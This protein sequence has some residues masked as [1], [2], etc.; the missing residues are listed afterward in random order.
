MKIRKVA[1]LKENDVL[2]RAVMTDDYQILLSEGVILKKE[3]IKKLKEF[4]IQDVY[5]EENKHYNILEIKALSEISE[6]KIK[7]N[8]KDILERHVYHNSKELMKLTE[9]ADSI[10]VDILKE[11]RLLEKVL[12]IKGRSADLYEHSINVCALAIILAIK[13][14]LEIKQIHDIAVGCLLHDLG[15]R[16]MIMDYTDKDISELNEEERTEYIKHPIYGYSAV[17]YED[18]LSEVSKNI[19]LSHHEHKNRSGYPLKTLNMSVEC[20]IVSICDT[21]D[22]MNCGIGYNKKKVYE[23]VEYM[24]TCA[25][26]HFDKEIINIFL[27]FTAVYPVGT[28]IVTNEGETAIIVKQNDQFPDRPVIYVIKDKEGKLIQKG[29]TIDLLKLHHI[30]IDKVLN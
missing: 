27:H 19:V 7:E 22:E 15:L 2:A 17:Q 11:E 26:E 24:K 21:F 12:D 29:K 9:A 18:W 13:R 20:Q 16:Y 23:A 8:I 28:E 10:I 4:Y 5:I 1:E 25:L 3:Y 30:F 6:K 14:G